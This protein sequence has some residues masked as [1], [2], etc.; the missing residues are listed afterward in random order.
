MIEAHI[1]DRIC[2]FSSRLPSRV[3]RDSTHAVKV[4]FILLS[5]GA[6]IGLCVILIWA[7]CTRGR[8]KLQKVKKT[9]YSAL[10]PRCT[11]TSAVTEQYVLSPPSVTNL[12]LHNKWCYMFRPFLR[13]I[14]R[15]QNTI[16]IK[17]IS[18]YAAKLLANLHR[19]FICSIPDYAVK[20]WLCLTVKAYHV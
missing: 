19:W 11:A 2:R 17:N 20:D 9:L 13:V 4:N 16:H 18:M 14:N 10:V 6:Y 7:A 8:I 15:Q 1:F 3:L 5:K 12:L